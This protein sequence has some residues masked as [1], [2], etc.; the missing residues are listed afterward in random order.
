[1]TDSKKFGAMALIGATNAGK[2]TLTNAMV[3]EK[4]AIVSHKVQ[5]TRFQIRGILTHEDT[6]IVLVDTPGFFKPR[7]KFDRAMIA[8]AWDAL[9]DVEIV[10]FLIDASKRYDEK[11]QKPYLEKIIAETDPESRILVLNKVDEA[12]KKQLLEI[13]AKVNAACPFDQT[14]MVSALKGSGVKDIIT[15]CTKK[16]PHGE[17]VYDADDLTTLPSRLLAAE[18]TREQIYNRLH[19]ELP[20]KIAV[21][22]EDFKDADKG[23]GF[24]ITQIIIIEDNKHK[25]IVLGK[26]GHTIKAIGAQARAELM[27]IFDCPIHLSLYV[28]HREGWMDKDEAFIDFES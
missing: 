8:T 11:R 27:K 2:S 6:Q 14:F 9:N 20:Y 25:S 17:W 13:A 15:Y 26:Q 10:A 4:V 5:T 18:I 28:Q 19:Q 12:P 1:M 21:E 7:R 24:A 22:T 3:G 23:K 16:L